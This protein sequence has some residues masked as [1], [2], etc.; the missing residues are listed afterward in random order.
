MPSITGSAAAGPMSPRPSTA[1]PSVTM[2]TVFFLMVSSCA[3]AGWSAIAVQTRATPGVYAI[4]R[5]SRSRTGMRA[6]T[7][8][9]PPSCMANVRSLSDSTCTPSSP[10]IAAR[11]CSIWATDEQLTI[12][13]SSRYSSFASNPFRATMLPPASPMATAS[14]PREPGLLSSRTRTVTEYAAVGVGIGGDG[15]RPDGP[16]QQEISYLTADR[17]AAAKRSTYSLDSPPYCGSED[18]SSRHRRI[19]EALNRR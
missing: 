10:S 14:R 19:S 13:S 5:S 1:V 9:L 6:S 8:I 2:A 11:I 15:T 17:C 4:D 18:I 7:S 16:P 12:T 3:R